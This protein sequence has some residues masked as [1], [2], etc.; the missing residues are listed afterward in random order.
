MSP[1]ASPIRNISDTARWVAVYR[2]QETQRPDAQFRDPFASRLA[3]ERG[4]EIAESMPFAAKASWSFV[5]RT[6][7]VD[8]YIAE[9]IARGADLVINLA[10]GLDA[11]PY[12]MPLPASLRWVEIDLPEILDYK[13]GLLQEEKPACALERVKL[14]LAD[15]GARREVFSRLARG[16]RRAVIVTE[17]LLVYL[18][19]DAVESLAADLAASPPFREWII[20]LSSPALLRM[21]E[22]NMGASLDQAGAPL[23]FAPVEGPEFFASRGW[24][25]RDVGSILHTAAR[26]NRLPFFLSLVSRISS[27][28]FQAAR[29]WSAVCRLEREA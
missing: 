10:A 6:W 14:D 5:A 4:R 18:T 13:T 12:R 3:G 9:G 27:P 22:K 21:L 28:R 19:A 26:L 15:A 11:R 1:P 24:K 23:R 17:G 2:A 7:L 8:R 16:V 25:P 29:P 20:D